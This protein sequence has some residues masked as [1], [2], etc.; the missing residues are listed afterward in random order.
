MLDPTT[1]TLKEPVPATF[2]RAVALAP[3]TSLEKPSERL[4]VFKTTLNSMRLH[5][6]TAA[7]ARQR[8]DV[9]DPQLDRS[10]AV[11]RPLAAVDPPA[12]PS[13]APCSVTLTDPDVP[14]L[15]RLVALKDA[16]P[17]DTLLE[18]LPAACPAVTNTRRLVIGPAPPKH[19]AD[20]SD[21]HD[22]ASQPVAP[23]LPTA[24]LDQEPIPPPCT[25]TLVEP[26]AARLTPRAQLAAADPT[27]K[28]KLTLPALKPA[29]SKTRPLPPS[30]VSI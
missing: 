24:V 18:P 21:V 3:A 22:V 8:M 10:H 2:C 7:L 13:P 29:D 15:A 5:P 17:T 12:S 20:E 19:R 25:V 14:R 6:A 11:P 1:V 26:V 28:P 9:S 27:E 4:P 23:I 16:R 30:P